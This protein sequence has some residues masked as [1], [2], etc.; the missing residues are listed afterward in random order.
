LVEEA[1]AQAFDARPETVRQAHLLLG[2]IAETA[3][4]A[5]ERKLDQASLVPF[6]PVKVML[7]SPEPT[8]EEVW[9]RVKEAHAGRGLPTEGAGFQVWIEDK[10]D[11][12]RCQ[13]H[14]VGTRVALY[15]RDSK[16]ITATFPDLAD[17][18]RTLPADCILDGEIV[19]M[20][21]DQILPFSELQRRL[22]R[23][24]EDLFMRE[25]VPAKL[26]IFD[27]LWLNAETRLTL[28][29]KERR[30]ILETL[31]PLPDSI[32]LARITRA[33]S[34]EAIEETFAAARRRDNE[35]L[36]IKDPESP[37]TPGRRGLAWLKLKKPFASLDC[38]VVGA[39][40]GHGR[41]SK[42]LSDYTFAVRDEVAG[43][44]KVIGKAYSGLTDAEIDRLTS[45]FLSTAT[46][47]HGR[48]FEVPPDTVLEVAFDRIQS[49]T[50]H[51]SGLA[52]RFPRIIRLRA[53]K[54]AQEIDT[55]QTA[56]RL[57]GLR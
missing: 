7:A 6:R 44:L 26:V 35:G 32:R 42:V 27:L 57:A 43:R 8:A 13:M 23:R 25:D 11:G 14:K 47:Q 4:L 34:A 29:L 2:D 17:S 10:Y 49:S 46:R 30:L 41:R 38:V 1:I 3:K 9:N 12:I 50:R 21:G 19:A 37:Y 53:D 39:E 55:L 36:M 16:E 18:L 5:W 52:L 31:Q 56:R 28:P 51:E 48:F 15:S 45:H 40:Y 33:P 54:T 24:E 22:G 20:R